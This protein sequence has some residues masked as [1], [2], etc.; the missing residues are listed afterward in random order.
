MHSVCSGVWGH[1]HLERERETETEGEPEEDRKA[2][3]HW[4]C[5]EDELLDSLSLMNTACHGKLTVLNA[6]TGAQSSCALYSLLTCRSLCRVHTMQP[7]QIFFFLENLTGQ[8]QDK[9]I[10]LTFSLAL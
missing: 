3:L 8:M 2:V 7:S 6:D 5:H 10:C 1:L 4:S 9:C